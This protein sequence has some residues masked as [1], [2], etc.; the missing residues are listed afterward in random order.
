MSFNKSVTKHKYSHTLWQNTPQMN[1]HCSL[2]WKIL[3]FRKLKLFIERLEN[4]VYSVGRFYFVWLYWTAVIFRGL[5]RW[6]EDNL[7]GEDRVDCRSEQF[8]NCVVGTDVLEEEQAWIRMHWVGKPPQNSKTQDTR[9]Q[10]KL[11]S[12]EK[13]SASGQRFAHKEGK[14]SKNRIVVAS[15]NASRLICNMLISIITGSDF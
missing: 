13:T 2:T 4:T 15:I 7:V 12:K 9:S 14:K 11:T 3:N 1:E 5:W 10:F 8:A 6:S